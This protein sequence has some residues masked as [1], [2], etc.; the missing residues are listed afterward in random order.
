MDPEKLNRLEQMI[1]EAE[2]TERRARHIKHPEIEEIVRNLIGVLECLE[3]KD[4]TFTVEKAK[5]V[6]LFVQGA[7]DNADDLIDNIDSEE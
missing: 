6:F 5:D 1:D 3:C 2:R 7:L 4:D